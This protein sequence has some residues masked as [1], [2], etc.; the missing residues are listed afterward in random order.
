MQKC[1]SVFGRV[2][3]VESLGALEGP[4]LRFV[5]FLQGC[6]IRCAYCHNPDTWDMSNG[7]LI[8]AKDQVEEILR[9]K[10]YLSG[11][12]TL[13]GGEP[14]AQAEFV[15]SLINECHLHHLHTAIDTSGA[16]PLS[17]CKNAVTA[18][19]LILLD[20]KSFDQDKG[21]KLC[22]IDMNQAWNL[23]DYCQSIGKPV[24]IRHVLVPGITVMEKNSSGTPLETESDFRIA[25]L[26]LVRGIQRL[27]AYS[28]IEKIELLPFH[29]LGEFKWENLSIPFSL[30]H[31][32]EP[33]E[34]VIA[35]S[36]KILHDQIQPGGT[37]C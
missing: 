9:Y 18:A 17:E 5:V 20:I 8:S 19:D 36:R 11:G 16:V 21:Q 3:S 26:E 1:N 22:G 35:W 10:N 33:S 4:G 29:K 25:N 27:K 31:V 28:C 32:D 2:H 23:L 24:W 15:C 6:P 37:L 34:H 30:H 12:V 13:S 7:K 14:L